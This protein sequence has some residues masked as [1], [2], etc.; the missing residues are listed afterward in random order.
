MWKCFAGLN[1][2]WFNPV[3]FLQE[4]LRSALPYNAIINKYS[5]ENFH[6]TL[7]KCESL[8]QRIFP[9]LQK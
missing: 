6:G 1:F 7:E 4:N 2:R 3:K 5:W 8:A 9:R